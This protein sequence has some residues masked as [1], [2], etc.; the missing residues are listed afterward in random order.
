MC[1]MTT[2]T[3]TRVQRMHAL[4]WQTAGFRLIRSRQL[5]IAY[6]KHILSPP[7]TLVLPG[8][9]RVRIGF[10]RH[11]PFLPGSIPPDPLAY[12]AIRLSIHSLAP[13]NPANTR[14]HPIFPRSMSFTLRYETP[15]LLSTMSLHSPV[16]RS[17][18]RAL[19]ASS[20]SN[21]CVKSFP[22]APCFFFFFSFS[23]LTK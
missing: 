2:D 17:S 3:V 5:C 13:F 19:D 14:S 18:L 11:A 15:V 21:L 7:V 1:S 8:I 23:P 9:R 16:R 20:L 12:H 22:P 6:S 4:P 10:S